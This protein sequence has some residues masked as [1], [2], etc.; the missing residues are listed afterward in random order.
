MY[1]YMY[2]WNIY[3][4]RKRVHN[5]NKHYLLLDSVILSRNYCCN[6]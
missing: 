4:Y 2:M 6:Y 5:Y 3:F 1:L